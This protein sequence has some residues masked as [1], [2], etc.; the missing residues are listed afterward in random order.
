MK[1]LCPL[2]TALALTGC[3]TVEMQYTEP[4]KHGAFDAIEAQAN[5]HYEYFVFPKTYILVTPVDETGKD[6]PAQEHA[7]T[8]DQDD[9]N[10]QSAA[11][12]KVKPKANDKTDKKK[13][14]PRL[15][16]IMHRLPLLF[17]MAWQ[18]H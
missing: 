14:S 8:A 2:V 18:L 11:A 1:T 16:Q 6:K 9:K 4:A 5:E 3:E 12:G 17:P 7:T 10:K 13:M 15:L